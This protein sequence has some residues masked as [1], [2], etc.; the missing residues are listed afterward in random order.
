MV[1]QRLPVKLVLADGRNSTFTGIIHVVGPDTP[2]RY[3]GT[4]SPNTTVTM[5]YYDHYGAGMFIVLV[6]VVYALSIVLLIA[7]FIKKKQCSNCSSEE[8]IVEHHD[9]KNV[10]AYLLEIQNLKDITAR[11]AFRKLKVQVIKEIEK[12]DS[13][14]ETQAELPEIERFQASMKKIEKDGRK[15]KRS[16]TSSPVLGKAL[17]GA[18]T[19]IY[20]PLLVTSS[21]THQKHGNTLTV[22]GEAAVEMPDTDD[23]PGEISIRVPSTGVRT[24]LFTNGSAARIPSQIPPSPNTRQRQVQFNDEKTPQEPSNGQQP[25]QSTSESPKE[26]RT[27]VY[28]PPTS[29][30]WTIGQPQQHIVGEIHTQQPSSGPPP[31]K[32]CSEQASGQYPTILYKQPNKPAQCD[33]SVYSVPYPSREHQSPHTF[34]ERPTVLSTGREAAG[35]VHS[36]VTSPR[37]AIHHTDKT[38]NH[39]RSKGSLLSPDSCLSIPL[40]NNN[41]PRGSIASTDSRRPS[42]DYTL[43]PRP[44][45]PRLIKSDLPNVHCPA[46]ATN[47]FNPWLS[48]AP[49]SPH[50][51]ALNGVE[52][53]FAMDI[54]IPHR[55]RSPSGGHSRNPSGGRSRNSSGGYSIPSSSSLTK[56]DT[57]SCN[58]TYKKPD[59]PWTAQSHV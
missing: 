26:R 4:V 18:T 42:Q 16:G 30:Q 27:G 59:D 15:R 14:R 2:I 32:L 11:N 57:L 21:P 55:N 49:A 29:S 3:N 48:P 33:S 28:D 19:C 13:R 6:I 56:G 1:V 25:Q 44:R 53:A 23:A 39:K 8:V 34:T 7:S 40:G 50:R 51:D 17:L 41:T 31:Q 22:P 43:P 45:S 10:N 20:Q 37:E 46:S 35:C 38:Q 58:C 24:S 47:P 54:W 9:E 12:A 36:D 52:N 5:E